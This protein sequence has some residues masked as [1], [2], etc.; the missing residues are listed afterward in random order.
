MDNV[1]TIEHACPV[2]KG[3]VTGNDASLYF[4]KHCNLLFRRSVLE[5]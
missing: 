1:L 4:C 5:Q 3:D 2:C